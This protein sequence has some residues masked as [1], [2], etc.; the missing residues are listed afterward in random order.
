MTTDSPKHNSES[1]EPLERKLDDAVDQ[2]ETL[3]ASGSPV[4]SRIVIEGY[5]IDRELHRGGQGVVYVAVQKS[6]KRKVAIKILLEGRFASSSA[7]RRFQREVA[8]AAG[9]KHPNIIAIFDSG[10]TPDGQQFCVMD[11]VR[12]RSI[13]DHVRASKLSLKE[14]L[15]LF[16]SVCEAAHFANQRGVVH[17]DLKPSNIIVDS[18][19]VPRVLDFGLAKQLAGGTQSLVSMTGQVMGTLQ[20]MSPEQTRGN[21]DEID[22]RSDVYSLGVIL[23]ELLTGVLPYSAK[24]DMV[25]V[26]KRIV[27]TEPTPPSKVWTVDSGVPRRKT[28]R[29]RT[30]ECPIDDELQTIVLKALAKDRN[31]RYQSVDALREDI[32]RYLEGRPIAAKRDSSLY[33][34]KKTLRRHRGRIIATLGAIAIALITLFAGL[35]FGGRGRPAFVS[36]GSFTSLAVLPL[37]NLSGDP[38][39]DYFADGMT[40]ALIADLAKISALRV[41]SRTSV[42]RYK[43]TDLT[44]PQIADELNVDVIVEGSVMRD[45]D[46]V[47][48]TAQ[49]IEAASD[50]HLW[51]ESYVRDVRDILALQGEVARAIAQEIKITLTGDERTRLTSTRRIN[52]LAHEAYLKGR[53]HWN[54]FNEQDFKKALDY[55]RQAIGYDP[56]YAAAYAGLADSYGILANTGSLAPE[57]AFPKAKSFA[58]KA[59]ELDET[60]A[61]AH[62]SLGGIL[63]THDWNFAAAEVEFLRAIQLQP[64]NATAHHWYAVLV[65]MPLGR[66]EDAHAQI[67]RAKELDPLSLLVN[68]AVGWIYYFQREYDKA[69]DA[70]TET[71]EMQSAFSAGHELLGACYTEKGMYEKAIAAYQEAIALSSRHPNLLASLGHAYALAGKR[72][73]AL[74]LLEELTTRSKETYVPAFFMAKLYLGLGDNARTFEW[75]DRAYVERSNILTRLN[76]HPAFDSLRGDPRFEELLQRIDLNP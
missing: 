49:L 72:E 38:G 68:N 48:I 12:G 21:P 13:H 10:E 37:E 19:G 76:H 9:L 22:A 23:Y 71:L 63:V 15:K 69:I 14:T 28:R 39:Q 74:A 44:L 60:L 25:E 1:D 67:Q 41:I 11:Y 6:T 33:V 62:A 66:F 35:Q 73:P 29:F 70:A 55:F 36:P 2:T 27:E 64:G 47:R 17:R 18:D 8:L 56:T 53:Y 24:G 26:L 20:Y 40:E 4:A 61:E 45:G 34:L 50:R 59:L 16:S 58:Q 54:K 3:A 31:R 57:K 5:E 32:F 51:A 46:R 75:L 42:M 30:G 43:K 52:R 7:R 65:L